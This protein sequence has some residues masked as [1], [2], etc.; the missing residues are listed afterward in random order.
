MTIQTSQDI[1]YL[2]LAIAVGLLAI[3]LVWLIVEAALT[4]HRVNALTRK[5]QE[6]LA[7][8]E[9]AMMSIRE[10]VEHSAGYVQLIAAAAK[11]LFTMFAEKK[12]K[13]RKK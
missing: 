11:Q 5:L 1:L 8:I 4:L 13:G 10:K 2:V 9:A 7:K 12:E 6:T 3:A